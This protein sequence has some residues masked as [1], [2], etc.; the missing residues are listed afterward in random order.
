VYGERVCV[1]VDPHAVKMQF[2]VQLG[3]GGGDLFYQPE[4]G[5]DFQCYHVHLTCL[6]L[7][8]LLTF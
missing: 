8:F 3:H 6:L 2:A 1:R 4:L 7:S 5:Q